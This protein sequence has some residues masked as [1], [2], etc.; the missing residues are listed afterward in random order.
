[1]DSSV[2]ISLWTQFGAT[3]DMLENSMLTCPDTLWN[4]SQ[5]WYISYHTLFYL[6][7]YLCDEPLNF[8][9]PE[10]FTLSEFEPEGK[11][12]DRVYNKPEL[13]NYLKFCRNKCKHLITAFAIEDSEKRFV[14]KQKN[15][16]MFEIMLYNLRH[17][18]HHVGQLNLLLRQNSNEPPK[19]VS[20]TEE[21]L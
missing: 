11:L 6:D 9:P 17:V 2:N 20:Q 1:V 10:P 7:Y 21:E 12:P 5:F 8:L 13:L 15:Y 3:I 14:S 16:S 4:G 19:W 18:Q